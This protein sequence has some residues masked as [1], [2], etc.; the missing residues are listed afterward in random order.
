MYSTHSLYGS[1]DSTKEY[2]SSSSPFMIL[3]K[4][5]TRS[6]P[7]QFIKTYR[8]YIEKADRPDFIRS[9]IT[10]DQDDSTVTPTFITEIKSI[11]PQSLIKVGYSGSKI[12]AVNRDMEHAGEYDILLL[13]SDDMVP[14]VK[15]YDTIIRDAMMSTYPDKD[16]VLFFN[17]GY[18]GSKLNTLSIMGKLYYE[19]F[20]YLYHPSYYSL[21][22]DN[23]FMKV[24]QRL[25]R[26]TYIEQVIIRHEHP[27][28]M[29]TVQKDPLYTQ[30]Y[31][32]LE[33]DRATYMERKKNGFP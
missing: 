8:E 29:T 21:F 24:A 10:L 15:G 33:Q 11:H 14:I 1:F 25:H 19:R 23:E 28:T 7:E 6:R 16:V 22:C 30:N 5:P 26:Q 32:Y 2:F 18:N 12:A 13:A 4:F 17:D 27:V 9:L 31:K 3:L 20:H